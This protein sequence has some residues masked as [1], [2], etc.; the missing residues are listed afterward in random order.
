MQALRK[1]GLHG[2]TRADRGLNTQQA[3][4]RLH[5]VPESE[6]ARD[7]VESGAATTI[8][9]HPD[10]KDVVARVDL[11]VDDRGAGVLGGGRSRPELPASVTGPRPAVRCHPRRPPRR[12][13]R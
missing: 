9:T 12:L 5:P 4:E 2:G 3:A 13:S 10:P 11:D 7:P 8:V 6:E 1:L